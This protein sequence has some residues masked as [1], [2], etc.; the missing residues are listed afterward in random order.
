[1]ANSIKRTERHFLAHLM[2]FR[3]RDVVNIGFVEI[4]ITPSFFVLKISSKK[5]YWVRPASKSAYF[6]A[7]IGKKVFKYN[8]HG[9]QNT[10]MVYLSNSE[11]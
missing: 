4:A 10:D 8:Y 11:R 2:H 3:S 7:E 6:C 1:M 9:Y 5:S